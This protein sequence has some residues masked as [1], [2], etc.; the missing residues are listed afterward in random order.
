MHKHNPFERI[1]GPD[2]CDVRV[3][4]CVKF[5]TWPRNYYNDNNV[6]WKPQKFLLVN[7]LLRHLMSPIAKALDPQYQPLIQGV[8]MLWQID[9]LGYKESQSA[10]TYGVLPNNIAADCCLCCWRNQCGC[11]TLS[12]LH[13]DF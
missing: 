4:F 13:N 2:N 7:L 9:V 6:M 1:R 5:F 3:I 10:L 12:E 11:A 8:S